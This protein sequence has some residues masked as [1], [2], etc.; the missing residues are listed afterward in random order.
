MRFDIPLDSPV[1]NVKHISFFVRIDS[2][3][4]GSLQA[5]AFYG[6][7]KE[8]EL[9]PIFLHGE[10]HEM[11]C[12]FSGFLHF[13]A[14]EGTN[15]EET[16][17]LEITDPGKEV[18]F[19]CTL[20][21]VG[22][23]Q[24]GDYIFLPIEKITQ[25][26]G[27]A[28]VEPEKAEASLIPLFSLDTVEPVPAVIDYKEETVNFDNSQ[29]FSDEYFFLYCHLGEQEIYNETNCE[30]FLPKNH[31]LPG[32]PIVATY[33]NLYVKYDVNKVT[34]D[35]MF[36]LEGDRPG[37]DKSRDYVTLMFRDYNKGSSGAVLLPAEG[38]RNYRNYL[39]GNYSAHIMQNYDD[40]VR[41]NFT[42]CRIQETRMNSKHLLP[43]PF[44][45][46]R[47][48]GFRN[49]YVFEISTHKDWCCGVLCVILL[50]W[51]ILNSACTEWL[52]FLSIWK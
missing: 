9:Q 19:S 28:G 52:M 39:H 12:P 44:S 4:K 45:L 5:R 34:I 26:D 38:A 42:R 46:L 25:T 50:F 21:S 30:L 32:E 27:F 22:F 24:T 2:S 43:E 23:Q 31:Y 13:K 37:I 1:E 20:Y 49:R 11:Q 6:I 47:Q 41:P 33:R 7:Q 3:K 15:I 48:I 40:L 17:S 8:N 35:V 36:Y 29:P 14:D 10:G 18:S 16:C 51:E